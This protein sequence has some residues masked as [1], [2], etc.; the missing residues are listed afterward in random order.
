MI[1]ATELPL[2]TP[3]LL[4]LVG[5]AVGW[6][7]TLSGLG[8]GLSLPLLAAV[9]LPL[10]AALLAVKL[11]VTLNDLCGALGE[12]RQRDG[13]GPSSLSWPALGIAG[14]AGALAAFAVLH[15]SASTFALV[16]PLWLLLALALHRGG[17]TW[18]GL[19]FWQAPVWGV[20][21]GG[22]G[23]GAA[24]LWR[25]GSPRRAARS[26][27]AEPCAGLRMGSGLPL[28][29]AANS[30]ALACLLLVGQQATG[31]VVLLAMAQGLGAWLATR[32]GG[33]SR[34]FFG[35]TG[36]S[37]QAPSQPAGPRTQ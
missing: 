31:E 11:P 37:C 20:Y 21:V 26:Q 28:R 15:L 10:P 22:C 30:G 4:G 29:A 16:A 2:A 33:P 7:S 3:V 25:L 27:H 23:I 13:G 32:F 18:A 24:I 19:R 35:A 9:G 1:S 36:P 14:V 34:L 6:A 12:R 8:A 17:G 5:L